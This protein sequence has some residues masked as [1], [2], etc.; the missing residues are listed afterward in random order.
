M[1]IAKVAARITKANS[2]S[3]AELLARVEYQPAKV[4]EVV[5]YLADTFNCFLMLEQPEDEEGIWDG[6]LGWNGRQFVYHGNTEPG[7]EGDLVSVVVSPEAIFEV[8]NF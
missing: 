5:E 4:I 8:C 1:N 3:L 7:G 2:I 6:G